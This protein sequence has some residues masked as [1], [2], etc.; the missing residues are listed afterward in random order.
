MRKRKERMRKGHPQVGGAPADS[1]QT[2]STLPTRSINAEGDKRL[3]QRCAWKLRRSRSRTQAGSLLH[4]PLR[5]LRRGRGARSLGRNVSAAFCR[6]SEFT[7]SARRLPRSGAT[8]TPFRRVWD[9]VWGVP[10]G[11]NGSDRPGS[12][13]FQDISACFTTNF[14]LKRKLTDD[15]ASATAPFS[16]P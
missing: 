16:C 3:R 4:S 1:V 15:F 6:P 14:G 7:P 5:G 9:S 11:R 10:G 2:P 8:V 12:P 13:D